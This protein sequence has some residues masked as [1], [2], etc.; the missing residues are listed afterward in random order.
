MNE[1]TQWYNGYILRCRESDSETGTDT[2]K[3][4]YNAYSVK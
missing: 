2:T 1:M 3:K 4:I